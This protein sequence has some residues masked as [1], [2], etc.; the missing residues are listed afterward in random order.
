MTFDFSDLELYNEIY[1]PLLENDNRYL[2]L[3]GSRDSGKSQ[4][5]AQKV[6]ID[7]LS[8]EYCKYILCRKT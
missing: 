5:A 7:L 4:F 1:L 3:Y 8:K 2:L 6:L